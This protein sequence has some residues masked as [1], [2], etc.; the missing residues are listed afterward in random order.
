VTPGGVH[1]PVRAFRSVGGTPI[2]FARGDGPRLFDVEGRGYIDFCQSFGPLILG[3]ADP[4]VAA[5][6]REAVGDG[7]SFGA[8]EPYSLAL[9]EWI[10]SRLP[11]VERVRFVSS[12]TEAVM[13][14]LRIA[15]AATGRSKV[16]KFEGCYHGHTDAMLVQAG[17]GLATGRVAASSAG[18]PDGILA[19]T[20]V[21]PLDDLPALEQIFAEQGAS[22]A[23]VILEPLPA[24]YGLLPQ[25]EEW[26]ARVASFARE[27]GA[28]LFFD[29]VI[30]G[31]RVGLG[32]MARELGIT[33]DLVTYGKVIGGGFPVAAYAGRADLMEQVAPLGPVYQAGTLSANPVGMRAG[34]AT[35]S[36]MEAIDGWQTLHARTEQFCDG[37]HEDFLRAGLPIEVIRRASIFWLRPKTADMVRRVD[38]IPAEQGPW[39]RRLFHAA[40]ARGV[41]LPPSGYEV[42]FLSMAHDDKTLAEARVAIA[43]AAVEAGQPTP[44]AEA[45]P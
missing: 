18:V 17:S 30:S 21:A 31:F 38:A 29:E 25:R 16:L 39:F 44:E 41:Y 27:H 45:R 34:L 5:A 15:R 3:H 10:T 24:N 4:D 23:A 33:P 13:S 14:A 7:W 26:L 37:L 6:V 1:S 42:C 2:F 11:W 22:I 8:C 32:G 19:D 43:A 28:L 9:A 40:V 36:K 12:G 35:L 20:L